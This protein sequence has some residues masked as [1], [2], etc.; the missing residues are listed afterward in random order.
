[1]PECHSNPPRAG[2]R[3]SPTDTGFSALANLAVLHLPKTV[4]CEEKRVKC[5]LFKRKVCPVHCFSLR[6]CLRKIRECVEIAKI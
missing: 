1:M 4:T 5:I 2:Q 3:W 6:M